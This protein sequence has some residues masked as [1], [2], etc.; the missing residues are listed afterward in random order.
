M[1]RKRQN[2]DKDDEEEEEESEED[3]DK[4]NEDV[5][6]HVSNLRE[7]RFREF[8]SVEYRDEIFMVNSIGWFREKDDHPF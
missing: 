4:V 6:E 3:K 2:D 8:A 1:E 5:D 7:R